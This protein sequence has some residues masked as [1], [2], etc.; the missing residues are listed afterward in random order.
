MSKNKEI[1]LTPAAFRK[2]HCHLNKENL[3]NYLNDQFQK[4]N[5]I[6]FFAYLLL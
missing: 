4:M 3:L 6:Y 2:K 1:K 5:Y